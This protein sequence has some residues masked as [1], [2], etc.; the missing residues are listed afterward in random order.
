MGLEKFSLLN[1]FPETKKADQSE[2]LPDREIRRE[3]RETKEW[4]ETSRDSRTTVCDWMDTGWH[5]VWWH[6]YQL[7]TWKWFSLFDC[8][9]SPLLQDIYQQKKKERT[10]HEYMW[11]L[12]AASTSTPSHASN[13]HQVFWTGQCRGSVRII[14]ALPWLPARKRE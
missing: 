3:F 1:N 12:L 9:E 8:L 5:A 10:I 6:H 4:F 14:S 7:L 11:G 2:P 13:I